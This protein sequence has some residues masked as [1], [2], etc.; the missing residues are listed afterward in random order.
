MP[1]STQK[2][3]ALVVGAGHAGVEASLSIARAGFQVCL[4]TMDLNTIA[5]MSCNPAIGGL[6]KGHIVREIDALG[7]EM[8]KAI[9]ATGIQ[10]RML[11]RA[12]GPAVWAPRAQADK[13]Q[14]SLYMKQRIEEEK[15]I[16]AMQAQA[17]E[18]LV[19]NKT[20]YGVRTH[21]G[22]EVLATHVVLTTGTFLQGLIHVG[23]VNYEGGRTGEK[24]AVG[25]SASLKENGIEIKLSNKKLVEL[26]VLVAS[27][28]IQLSQI[29]DILKS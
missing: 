27:S 26:C 7:G 19:K 2:F 4:M 18:L 24:P 23:D 11:N 20:C 22:Q 12:K 16:T 14:Y 17:K 28:H 5:K 25:L 13:K 3:D 1:H 8:A 15:N 9:D 21:E 29:P 6:A 10:F